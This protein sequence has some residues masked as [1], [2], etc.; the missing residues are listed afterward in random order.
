MKYLTFLDYTTLE[1]TGK[2]IETKLLE[3]ENEIQLLRERDS[4]NADAIANPSDQITTISARL[5]ELEISKNNLL[6]YSI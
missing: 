4:M 3:K 6:I 2:N 1:A 5:Q